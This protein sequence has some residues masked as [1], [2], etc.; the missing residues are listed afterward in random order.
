MFMQI[1]DFDQIHKFSTFDSTGRYLAELR[2]EAE[3]EE[4]LWAIEHRLAVHADTW[5]AGE[6]VPGIRAL[7]TAA[8]TD[9]ALRGE[10]VARG[11]VAFALGF[12]LSEAA[13]KPAHEL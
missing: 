9:P 12:L 7:F 1:I 11:A 3:V 5:L 2:A 10:I 6:L 8:E 13:Q 4:W